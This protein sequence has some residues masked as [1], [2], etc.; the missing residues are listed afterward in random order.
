[1]IC[2]HPQVHHFH[3]HDPAD[4]PLTWAFS[5]GWPHR[6][7]HLAPGP[8]SCAGERRELPAEVLDVGMVDLREDGPGPLP[9]PASA[10]EVAS[11]VPGVAEVA[12]GV[13]FAVAIAGLLE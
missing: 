8:V 3:G 10:I 1:M 13:G 5:V 2:R 12:E 4:R 6:S 9:G 11:G 7:A